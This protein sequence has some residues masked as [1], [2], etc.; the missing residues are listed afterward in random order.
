M[1]ALKIDGYKFF[2]AISWLE[3]PMKARYLD[4]RVVC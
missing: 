3:G 1:N 4:I 2:S